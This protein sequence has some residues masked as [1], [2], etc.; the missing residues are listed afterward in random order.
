MY[1]TLPHNKMEWSDEES[2]EIER[3]RVAYPD[4]PF[5]RFLPPLGG[6]SM[7]RTVDDGGGGDAGDVGT[8]VSALPQLINLL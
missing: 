4:P 6:E 1:V 8:P 2:A 5:V 7:N 3:I